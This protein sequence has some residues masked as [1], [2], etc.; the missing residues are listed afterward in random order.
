[1]AYRVCVS[2]GFLR[3]L[4]YLIRGCI[5]SEL[6]RVA[7]LAETLEPGRAT[8]S[9]VL[10]TRPLQDGY[11]ISYSLDE[12]RRTVKLMVIAQPKKAT[13]APSAALSITPPP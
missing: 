10:S 5:R 2:E 7:E 4:P 1:M 8:N 6:E 9:N 3:P 12:R 13:A 11:W